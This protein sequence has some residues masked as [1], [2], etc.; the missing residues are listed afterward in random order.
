MRI[1]PDSLAGRTLA[2]LLGITLLLIAGSAILLQEERNIRFEEQNQFRLLNSISTL[3]RLVEDAE[4]RERQR[5]VNHINKENFHA[6]IAVTP[7][8]A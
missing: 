1:W 6:S 7:L 2:I 4:Q 8:V 3:V 5:I